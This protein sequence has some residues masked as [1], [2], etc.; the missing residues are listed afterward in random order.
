M[1]T[2]QLELLAPQVRHSGTGVQADRKAPSTAAS[3]A[4]PTGLAGLCDAGG[5]GCLGAGLSEGEPLVTEVGND[6]QPGDTLV[7]PSLDR[8]SRSL[9]D[10]IKIVGTLRREGIGFKSLHEALDTTT[11]AAG[12]SSMSSP[13]SPSSSGN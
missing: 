5:S 3:P 10:L 2:W 11:R 12:S 7:V 9:A 6:L 13:R 8:L 1:E 4:L